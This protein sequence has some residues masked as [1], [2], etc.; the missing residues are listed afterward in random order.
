M[1]TRDFYASQLPLGLLL[2]GI[3]QLLDNKY[4]LSALCFSF[5]SYLHPQVGIIGGSI[6]FSAYFVSTD[7]T[8]AI[9]LVKSFMFYAVIILPL[10][11]L[12]KNEI[13]PVF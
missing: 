2:F 4:F 6:A 9:R 12:Y 3:V 10:Y 13:D 8:E 11:I 1:I 7:K 5:A